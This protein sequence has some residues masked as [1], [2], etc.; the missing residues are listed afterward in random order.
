MTDFKQCIVVRKDL[1][2][3][4]G[5]IAAQSCHAS[6]VAYDLAKKYHPDNVR[7]WKESGQKKVVLK[8]STEKELIQYF[9]ECKDAGIPCQLI[10]DAGMTQLEPGTKTAFAA[11]P[12]PEAAL[13]RILSKLKLL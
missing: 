6:L 13:D 8:V 1:G 5:K 3:G 10:Q 2:M 4:P 11:G 9:Q 7:A 12:W